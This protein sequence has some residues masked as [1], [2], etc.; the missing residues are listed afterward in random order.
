MAAFR[1]RTVVAEK[2]D[3]SRKPRE[4]CRIMGFK[5]KNCLENTVFR[6]VYY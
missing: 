3:N 6:I 1:P 4:S 2:L 5:R